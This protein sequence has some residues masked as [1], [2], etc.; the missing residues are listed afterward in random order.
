MSRRWLLGIFAACLLVAG[1]VSSALAQ[2]AQQVKA[3]IEAGAGFLRSGEIELATKTFT[4]VLDLDATNWQAR[5]LLA[6]TYLTVRD[7]AKVDVELRRLK[8]QN[9]PAA[10]VAPIE[11]QLDAARRAIQQRDQLTGLLAAGK[12]QETLTN[13]D[14][15]DVQDS[16]K[17]LLKAYVAA[18]RGEF[19][20]ARRLTSESQFAAFNASIEKRSAEFQVARD[21][22][23]VALNFLGARYCGGYDRMW[24]CADQPRLSGDQQA[25]WDE[26]RSGN[27]KVNPRFMVEKPDRPANLVVAWG[28]YYGEVAAM[29]QLRAKVA[30]ALINQFVSMAPL[31][32]DALQ[33]SVVLSLYSG[34]QD[35]VRA[36]ADRAMNTTGVWAIN[37]RTCRG[38]SVKDEDCWVGDKRTERELP[39]EGVI[40][41]D[42]RSRMLRYSLLPPR[43]WLTV[44][45]SPSGRLEFEIPFQELSVIR[46]VPEVKKTKQAF[47]YLDNGATLFDFGPKKSVR[48]LLDFTFPLTVF[49]SPDSQLVATALKGIEDVLNVM[50]QV[51]PSAKVNYQPEWAGRGALGVFSGIAG[52][53]QV[54]VGSA[55]GDAAALA[56]GQQI[57]QEQ[58]QRTSAGAAKKA[59]VSRVM[60]DLKT[61]DGKSLLDAAFEDEGLKKDLDALLA[62]ALQ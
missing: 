9:A 34:S 46:S 23:I 32:P 14:T 49:P 36:A 58:G 39:E 35:I 5:A 2:S 43:S 61:Q 19:D 47:P 54:V 55:T 48:M 62:L 6:L 25:A 11:R 59:D 1:A 26:I 33:A 28:P 56:Q 24:R 8:T 3:R 18:L 38:G 12:W 16:R 52:A 22:A 4:Q 29:T 51:I 13:I 20:E 57:L 53:T 10:A 21:K 7:Y 30:L 17:R 40:I 37:T 31:H 42:G 27:G 41:V 60:N 15:A 50:G 45:Q 44:V